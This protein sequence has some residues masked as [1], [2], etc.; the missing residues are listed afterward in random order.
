MKSKR[1]GMIENFIEDS[2]INW[3]DKRTE[4]KKKRKERKDRWK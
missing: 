4:I 3:I 2:V 1:T